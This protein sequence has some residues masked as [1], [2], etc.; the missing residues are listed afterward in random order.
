MNLYSI[1]YLSLSYLVS[2]FQLYCLKALFLP[3]S[4]RPNY[5]EQ[6]L[7]LVRTNRNDFSK[8]VHN[9]LSN[10]SHLPTVDQ[11]IERGIKIH[12]SQC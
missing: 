11:G 9:S 5:P 3:E 7:S 6:I 8:Y 4:K 1:I 12:K 10:V 2:F